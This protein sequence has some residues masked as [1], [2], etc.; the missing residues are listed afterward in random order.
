[1]WERW[2][3]LGMALMKLKFEFESF[4]IDLWLEAE[5]DRK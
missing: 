5:D 2:Q 1:M 3:P 4:F